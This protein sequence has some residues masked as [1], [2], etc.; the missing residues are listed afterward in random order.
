MAYVNKT[1]LRDEFS[2]LKG[3]FATL[4]AAGKVTPESRVLFNALLM[5]LEV[6]MAVF[7]EKTTPK[8]S[9]NSSKPSSQMETPDTSAAQG[10]HAR[11][12]AAEALRIP[13]K[14]ARYSGPCRP[15]G[16]A[17]T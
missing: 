7:L 6:M 11:A 5:L 9:R 15:G 17:V 8:T 16:D 10:A 4:A 2:H 12:L 1:S 14:P 3:E 13:A